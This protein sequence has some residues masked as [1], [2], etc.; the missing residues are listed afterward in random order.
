MIGAIEVSHAQIT[1]HS[2]LVKQLSL[3]SSYR[4]SAA[5]LG[6]IGKVILNHQFANCIPFGMS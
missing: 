4:A 5:Y 6:Y 3:E 1:L 2:G